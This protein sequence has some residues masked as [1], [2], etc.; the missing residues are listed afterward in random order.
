ML[1]RK[2][3]KDVKVAVMH[4]YNAELLP[5][6]TILDFL[7]ISW[8]TLFHV[9]TLWI[10]TG[11]VVQLVFN[12]GTLYPLGTWIQIQMTTSVSAVIPVSI[13]LKSIPAMAGM[14]H[15]HCCS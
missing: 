10:E 1:F 8:R 9:C 15:H 6:G 5:L 4:M 7:K 12:T 14:D 3:S 13:S 2:I 11:D